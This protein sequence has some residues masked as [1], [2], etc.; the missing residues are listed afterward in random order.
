M[1]KTRT[2]PKIQPVTL[3]LACGHTVVQTRHVERGDFPQPMVGMEAVCWEF[4]CAGQ[5]FQKIEKVE[6]IA[7]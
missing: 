5:G 2:R 3:T 1:G 7:E 6:P 4:Q